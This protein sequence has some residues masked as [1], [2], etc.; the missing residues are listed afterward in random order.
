MFSAIYLY[1]VRLLS[2]IHLDIFKKKN[3]LKGCSIRIELWLSLA[4]VFLFWYDYLIELS[5]IHICSKWRYGGF[6]LCV[7]EP[8]DLEYG[9]VVVI[10]APL[11]LFKLVL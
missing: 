8:K 5:K 10:V 11:I 4:F 2:Y 1:N 6:N 3:Y 9:F 7:V